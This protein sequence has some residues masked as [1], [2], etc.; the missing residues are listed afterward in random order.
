MSVP[1]PLDTKTKS[2]LLLDPFTTFEKAFEAKDG[3]GRRKLI[4]MLKYAR[5]LGAD[6]EYCLNLLDKV[7]N[8]WVKPLPEKDTEVI[9]NQIRRWRF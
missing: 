6:Q 7:N 4:W 5:E 9:R 3:E 8:Y 1:K 2:A